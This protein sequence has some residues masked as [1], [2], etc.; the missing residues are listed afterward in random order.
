LAGL[1]GIR[2]AVLADAKEGRLNMKDLKPLISGN[3]MNGQRKFLKDFTFRPVCKIAVGSNHR[4]KLP[5]T[6]MD[7]KRRVRMV[8]FDYTVPEEDVITHLDKVLLE[9]APEILALLIYFAGQY[10]AAG[11]GPRAFPVCQAIDETSRE[12]LESEDL[13]GRFVQDR[14]EPSPGAE[15]A[16]N[17]LYKDFEK[18][19]EAEGIRK[20]MSRN[21]FGDRL[22]VH[23]PGKVRKT[24]GVYYLDIKIKGDGG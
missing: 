1:P 11:G 17:D 7:V 21:T 10:Y 6:G 16:A 5:S 18:W 3:T 12:Y 9:E 22:K 19:E 20:K 15:T 2:L 14:T 13:V 24:S 23:V 4:L 8:P